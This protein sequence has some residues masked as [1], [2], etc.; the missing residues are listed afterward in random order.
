[1]ILSIKENRF[2]NHELCK[3]SKA[4][5]HL[6]YLRSCVLLFKHI[7]I[8]AKRLFLPNRPQS[9]VQARD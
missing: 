3:R 5:Q 1:M 7:I 9:N 6:Y 4:K 8:I 2:L